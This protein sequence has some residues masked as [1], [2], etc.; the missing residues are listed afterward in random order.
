MSDSTGATPT[1]GTAPSEFAPITSQADLDR[2]IGDRLSRERAKYAD[3]DDLKTKARAFDEAEQARLSDLEK[4]TKRA[5]KFEAEVKSLK[6][7]QLRFEVA[8]SKSVP[9]NL[10]TGATK[11]ELEASADALIEFAGAQSKPRTPQPNPT[12]GRN[13]PHA[14]NGDGLENMLRAKLGI[15]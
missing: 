12:Q 1:E 9:A 11:E 2:I 6:A 14:L 15:Q 5:E 10:L 3:Y 4:A 13:A 7:S 8:N